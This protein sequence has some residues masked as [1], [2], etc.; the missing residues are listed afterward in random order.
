MQSRYAGRASIAITANVILAL[1]ITQA[2]NHN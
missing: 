2:E 1:A